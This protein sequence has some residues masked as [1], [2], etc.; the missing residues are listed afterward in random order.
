MASMLSRAICILIVLIVAAAVAKHFGAGAAHPPVT[1]AVMGS[2]HG[3]QPEA[4]TDAPGGV[5]AT[6]QSGQSRVPGRRLVDQGQGIIADACQVGMQGGMNYAMNGYTYM[7]K[8]PSKPNTC[9]FLDNAYEP[10]IMDANLA[11]CNNNHP[12]MGAEPQFIREARRE[13]VDGR[14]RCVVELHPNKTADE[15]GEFEKRLRGSTLRRSAKYLQLKGQYDELKGRYD[16]LQIQVNG[17]RD[18][19]KSVTDQVTAQQQTNGAL[20]AQ[21]SST[22]SQV[23]AAKQRLEALPRL[24]E[25]ARQGRLASESGQVGSSAPGS[26]PRPPEWCTHPGATNQ[27]K[28]CMGNGVAGDQVCTDTAGRRGTI[29]RSDNCTP[30]W[31]NA[32]GCGGGSAGAV[33]AQAPQ[34]PQCN[35]EYG[36]CV[37]SPNGGYWRYIKYPDAPG[38]PRSDYY[39]CTP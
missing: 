33:Q 26:C 20:D 17:A 35:P 19:L 9:V 5:D 7:E 21:I 2:S 14:M 37:P 8:H 27:Q 30:I 15:Y 3:Q 1:A 34:A 31:P 28:D 25:Q 11:S 12:I 23:E 16:A 6:A 4:F 22:R 32:T 29:L 13:S 36:Q 18:Q 24:V 39:A 38:C 10:A